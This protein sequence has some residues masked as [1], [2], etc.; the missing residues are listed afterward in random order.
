MNALR[1]TL[2][3]WDSVLTK[4]K[5]ASEVTL[6]QVRNFIDNLKPISSIANQDKHREGRLN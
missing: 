4:R 2:E 1:L 3:W 5:D 6:N